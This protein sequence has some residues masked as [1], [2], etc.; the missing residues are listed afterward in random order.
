MYTLALSGVYNSDF[1]W[2]FGKLP[3]P[4]HYG[5]LFKEFGGKSK[6]IHNWKNKDHFWI[7]NDSLIR[8]PGGAYIKHSTHVLLE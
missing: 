7:G 4:T 1:I 3:F 8:R 6:K 5:N 2:H